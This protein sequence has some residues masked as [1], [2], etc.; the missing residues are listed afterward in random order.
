MT[1]EQRKARPWFTEEVTRRFSIYLTWLF[2]QLGLTAHQV[3]F[4]VLVMGVVSGLAFIWG[5]FL[6]AVLI[7]QMWYL[8][9][10]VDGEIARYHKVDDLTGRY[11]DILMHYG[12]EAW[13]FYAIGVGVAR[14][15]EVFWMQSLGLWVAFFF[16]FLKLIYDLK[17]KCYM[18][19]LCAA[20]GRYYIGKEGRCERI[21]ARNSWRMR[22]LKTYSLYPNVI[23]IITLCVVV[24]SLWG[25]FQ[26]RG[27]EWST[28]LCVMVSYGL[29][30][31]A[32]CVKGCVSILRH[33]DVDREVHRIARS[34]HPE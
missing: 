3:S 28:L 20:E 34:S 5:K 11:S 16:T 21:Q 17:Y 32:A 18:E 24:D 31:P 10:A 1:D 9:D 13:V 12:I 23:N 33:R 25:G 22:I 14:K 30:Y 26:W 2:L 4:L 19:H 27:V 15:Y 7:L 29:F 8:I 6:V